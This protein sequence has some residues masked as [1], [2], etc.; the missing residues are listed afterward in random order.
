MLRALEMVNLLDEKDIPVQNFSGGMKRRIGLAQILVLP[1]KVLIVDEPTVG[2]DPLER[3]RFRNMLVQLSQD[4]VVI[5]S[6]H[7]VEDVAH[8][9]R[10]LAL[11]DE[12]KVFYT[13]SPDDLVESVR[14][15]VWDLTVKDENAWHRLRRQYTVG[16][17]S[18]TAEGIRLRIV[19]DRAPAP[20]AT[21][22]D[23]SL[24]D[25]YLYH[26]QLPMTMK[27]SDDETTVWH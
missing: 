18:Y 3:L 26:T 14:G 9:C 17:Q 1:P 7:I 22:L 8:S 25:A 5:L 10:R 21:L 23:P 20:N 2:L 12:G 24:E 27:T 19:A 11:I 6:T 15:K 4:R 16:G 13:G